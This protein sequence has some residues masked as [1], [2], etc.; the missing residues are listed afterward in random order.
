MDPI[1]Y[2]AVTRSQREF[3]VSAALR[4]GGFYTWCPYTKERMKRRL[5]GR[6]YHI[7]WVEL[8]LYSRYVFV[9][10]RAGQSLDDVRSAIGVIG[11]V[12]RRDETP[13]IVPGD[14]MTEIMAYGD[15]RG[16]VGTHDRTAR[17][18]FEAGQTVE[19]AEGSLLAGFIGEV[20]VDEGREVTIFIQELAGKTIKIDPALLV[21][22]GPD[23]AQSRKS[24]SDSIGRGPRSNGAKRRRASRQPFPQQP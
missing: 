8:P 1:W 10:I 2:V 20:S 5:A 13:I 4:G 6:Q 16:L 11:I 12:S 17:Q 3:E 18:K 24:L 9:A 19:I 7:E 14:V 22:A 15:V 21:A 23:K